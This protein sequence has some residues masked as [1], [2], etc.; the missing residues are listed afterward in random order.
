MQEIVDDFSLSTL[1]RAMETNVQEAWVCLGRGLGAEIHNEPELLWF[2]SGIP[3]HLANGIVRA[4]FSPDS[5]EEILNERLKQLT[6]YGVPMAWLIGPST[7]PSDLG[8]YLERHGWSPDDEAPG[9]ALDLHRL[10]EHLSLPPRLIIE[11]VND[12]EM[13]KTWLRVM[14]VGSELPEEGLALLLDVVTRCGF[15]HDTAV[16]YYLGM[17]DGRPVATSLLYTGGGVAGIYNVATVPEA[18]RQGIGSALTLAPLLDARA[19]GY[20]IGILQSTAMGLNLYRR[21]GFKEYC[22]FYAYFWSGEQ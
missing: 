15:K 1:L 5:E 3:F 13:L 19:W 21:L 18:R 17:L 4:H 16:H 7:R 8:S 6:S 12:E 14:V 20:R 22:T 11:H 2:L 9:M 10:D